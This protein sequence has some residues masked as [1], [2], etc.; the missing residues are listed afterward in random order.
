MEAKGRKRLS[1][2]PD[3]R[4]VFLRKRKLILSNILK[5]QNKTKYFGAI[6][7]SYVTIL[8]ATVEII[9]QVAVVQ[10]YSLAL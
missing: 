10:W 8:F 9:S 6:V 3:H 4:I 5:Q 2:L 1:V 7:L